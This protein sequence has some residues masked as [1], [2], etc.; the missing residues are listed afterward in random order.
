M[1][2]SSE[3]NGVGKT[4]LKQIERKG[5]GGEFDKDYKIR[6]FNIPLRYLF[7]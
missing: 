1:Y 6:D 2:L 7:Y 5:G 3:N 4:Q